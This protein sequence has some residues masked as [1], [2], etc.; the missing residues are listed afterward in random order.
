MDTRWKKICD[1]LNF[2]G[3]EMLDDEGNPTGVIL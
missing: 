2:H 3:V 1:T